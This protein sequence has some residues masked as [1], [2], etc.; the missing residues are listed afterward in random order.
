MY[1][2][3]VEIKDSG[4]EGKGVFAMENVS[5][6][7]LVWR[8]DSTH[9]LTLS[10]Q[11]YDMLSAEA[12]ADI[13]KVGYVSFSSGKWVYPP[14]DDPARFTNHSE[15]ENNLTAKIDPTISDEPFFVANRDINKGEELTVNYVEFD[16]SIKQGRP[17]WMSR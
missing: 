11:E 16:D 10:S 5:T 1:L 15:T 7:D 8:F 12:K 2:K 9:D 13:R 17:D 14:E 4:I 3:R 6:G